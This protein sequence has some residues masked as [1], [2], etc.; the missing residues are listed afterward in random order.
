MR[1]HSS[2]HECLVCLSRT[3]H[4][5]YVSSLRAEPLFVLVVHQISLQII[6]ALRVLSHFKRLIDQSRVIAADVQLR[7][8][9]ACY[10]QDKCSIAGGKRCTWLVVGVVGVFPEVYLSITE[11]PLI[12]KHRYL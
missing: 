1:S 4:K 8:L 3:R 6:P 7:R 2:T 11:G 9:L 10:V 5:R 12:S